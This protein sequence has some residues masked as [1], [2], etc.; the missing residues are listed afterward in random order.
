LLIFLVMKSKLQA[1]VALLISSLFIGIASGMDLSEVIDSIESGM[2][3][4]LGFI[5]VVVGLG[6]MFG[7]LL[8]ASGGAE[9]LASTLIDK[10]GEKKAQWALGL[11]GFIISIP[12]YYFNSCIFRCCFSKN[13]KFKL[14]T[15]AF[16]NFAVIENTFLYAVVSNFIS[17]LNASLAVRYPNIL[18]GRL[19][20]HCWI[21]LIV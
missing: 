10:F 12:I 9:R 15:C 11:T 16:V 20:I 5:A 19:F 3:G 18:R 17:L 8:R 6:A 21:F 1:F 7:E 14:A 2:G 4:T 13:F